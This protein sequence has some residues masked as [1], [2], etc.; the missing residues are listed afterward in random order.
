[1]ITEFMKPL[2]C[3]FGNEPLVKSQPGRGVGV[4][5]AE[6]RDASR[7]SDENEVLE[8]IVAA[9][10]YS[11]AAF[12]TTRRE[13]LVVGASHPVPPMSAVLSEFMAEHGITA[14][15][16][17]GESLFGGTPGGGMTDLAIGDASAWCDAAMQS[18]RACMNADARIAG[19]WVEVIRTYVR[20]VGAPDDSAR[21]AA[22]RFVVDVFCVDEEKLSRPLPKGRSQQGDSVAGNRST[23]GARSG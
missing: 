8:G 12:L 4:G 7:P 1:M 14:P 15:P 5:L 23:T 10:L 6:C 3:G 9:A 18:L 20:G 21:E 2:A 19:N 11:F 13:E 16:G 17:F 22:V